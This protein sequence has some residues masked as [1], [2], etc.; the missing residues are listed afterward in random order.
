M[1]H[2]LAAVVFA[3]AH[4]GGSGNVPAEPALVTIVDLTSGA[5]VA[6]YDIPQALGS[7]LAC[8]TPEYFTFV[9]WHTGSH[10]ITRA[11][12]R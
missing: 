7:S 9:S 3:E 5:E 1:C 10:L 6:T 12:A 2:G 8:Y 4:E 11:V